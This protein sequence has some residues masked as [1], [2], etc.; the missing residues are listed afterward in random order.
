MNL[1][2]VMPT[3][4]KRIWLPAVFLLG[5]IAL[6]AGSA[7]AATHHVS[8][9]GSDKN[10]GTFAAPWRTLL[11]ARNV[12]LPGDITYAMDGVTQST[13]DGAGWDAAPHPG[14]A[15]RP[16]FARVDLAVRRLA[17][18]KLRSRRDGCAPRCCPPRRGLL[19]R[20][21]A[22]PAPAMVRSPA[23]WRD[24]T[25]TCSATP[26]RRWTRRD[27]RTGR[28]NW[29]WECHRP[30]WQRPSS[31]RRRQSLALWRPAIS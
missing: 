12:M 21:L 13:D 4:R 5:G 15:Q 17:A 31:I 16:G 22:P 6:I 18:R 26:R 24:C 29:R 23:S 3:A 1:N 28:G 2:F 7:R 30:A 10:A 14:Q 27:W 19:H 25:R 20:C 8:T 9:S 11:K